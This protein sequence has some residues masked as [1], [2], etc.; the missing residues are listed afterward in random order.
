MEK[1]DNN[2]N[3]GYFRFD[4]DNK[5]SYRY[6]LSI[7]YTEMGQL[8]IYRAKNLLRSDKVDSVNTKWQFCIFRQFSISNFAAFSGN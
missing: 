2:G 7:T 8:N 4:D 5:M 1:Y 6:I 3:G